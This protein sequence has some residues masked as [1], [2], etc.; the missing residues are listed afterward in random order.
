MNDPVDHAGVPRKTP[1]SV[2][3]DI[4]DGK[5]MR[6][7]LRLPQLGQYRT[8]WDFHWNVPGVRGDGVLI[9]L[10]VDVP[11]VGIFKHF[12]HAPFVLKDEPG[13]VS[14]SVEKTEI[15]WHNFEIGMTHIRLGDQV[16]QVNE[17]LQSPEMRTWLPYL[18]EADLATRRSGRRGRR[19]IEHALL[20]QRYV[21]LVDEG[22]RKPNQ[23]LAGEYQTSA[24]Q[25]SKRINQ[26]RDKG[27]LTSAPAGKAGGELTPKT[28]NV[29]HEASFSES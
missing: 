22:D 11:R 16:R 8:K 2:R 28:M 3:S 20:A 7:V 10:S 9:E 21:E 18:P 14:L 29:L 27:F 26:C 24:K 15:T 19:D 4:G 6:P 25:I 5:G 23:T 17:E 13:P 12:A 1:T